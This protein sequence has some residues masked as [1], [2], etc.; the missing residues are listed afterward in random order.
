MTAQRSAARVSYLICV[1]IKI[2]QCEFTR[3]TFMSLS[4]ALGVGTV[5]VCI[6]ALV[7]GLVMQWVPVQTYVTNPDDVDEEEG[8]LGAAA[9][10]LALPITPPARTLN[11][12]IIYA[13]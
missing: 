6:V 2:R 5:G 8:P 13:P 4:G 11:A 3:N 7:V 10:P 1:A 12:M 9:A